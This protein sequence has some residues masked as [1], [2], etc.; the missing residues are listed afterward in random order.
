MYKEYAYVTNEPSCAHA[1]LLPYV[2]ALLGP[3]PRRVLDLGCGDG[4]LACALL[5]DGHD[6]YGLDASRSGI[7]IANERAPGRFFIQDLSSDNLPPE[8]ADKCFD[9]IVSTEVSSISTTRA[10]C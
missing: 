6:V 8:L 9:T 4:A 1:Y 5:A 7:A 3:T 10:R 2:R